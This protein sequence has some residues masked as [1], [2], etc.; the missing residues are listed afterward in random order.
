MTWTRKERNPELACVLVWLLAGLASEGRRAEALVQPLNRSFGNEWLSL[1]FGA[2][3]LLLPPS[4][5]RT[6]ALL[7]HRIAKLGLHLR[8]LGCIMDEGGS[9]LQLVAFID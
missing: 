4:R 8:L 7:Q 6:G 2:P 9:V 3:L 1:S 5:N